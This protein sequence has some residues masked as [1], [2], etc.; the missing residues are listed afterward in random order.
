MSLI[1]TWL[2]LPSPDLATLRR[3]GVSYRAT[4]LVGGVRQG[5]NGRLLIPVWDDPPSIY[6]V[7]ED[8]VLLGIL[9]IDP[10]YPDRW[11][12]VAGDQIAMLGEA[13]LR[14]AIWYGEPLPV[15][16]NPLNW[17]RGGGAGVFP[18]DWK[19]FAQEV[20]WH[21]E[22]ELA[23]EDLETGDRLKRALDRAARIRKPRITVEMREA[24]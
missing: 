12:T 21:P 19:R 23:A 3:H 7:V 5:R 17:L 13:A 11:E 8:P 9:G 10:Q 2:R 4:Q 6:R 20:L 1:E 15:F 14:E 22:V 16:R 18:L 24:A